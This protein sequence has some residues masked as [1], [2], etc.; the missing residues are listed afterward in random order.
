ME[1]QWVIHFGGVFKGC[2]PLFILR[3]DNGT[4]EGPLINNKDEDSKNEVVVREG[5]SFVLACELSHFHHLRWTLNNREIT[6]QIADEWDMYIETEK[7]V[8]G[9]VYSEL[10]VNNASIH[11]HPGEYKCT[12]LCLD[13]HA[14]AGAGNL[15]VTVTVSLG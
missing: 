7:E 1:K 8:D 11:F 14:V 9:Y 12:P 4:Q 3:N 2:T 5:T 6:S 10:V 13:S 15:G